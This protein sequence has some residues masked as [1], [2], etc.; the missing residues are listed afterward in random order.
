MIRQ[1]KVGDEVKI[2]S[3]KWYDIN[4]RKGIDG[5]IYKGVTFT[6]SMSNYCGLIFT[7]V[8]VDN[9]FEEEEI[10]K[11]GS[12]YRLDL[13]EEEDWCW[14]AFMFEEQEQLEFDF[15]A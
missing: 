1:Y 7:I 14:Q 13:G 15:N 9:S 5:D 8:E 2:K 10:I 4:I 6:E 11:E 3:L 12:V